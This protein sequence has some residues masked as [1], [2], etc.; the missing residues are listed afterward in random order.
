MIGPGFEQLEE[1][2]LLASH[3][4]LLLE[5]FPEDVSDHFAAD[6]VADPS[7]VM[8]LKSVAANGVESAVAIQSS[9]LVTRQHALRGD[10][11]IV[12]SAF[13]ADG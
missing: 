1:R 10:L 8:S 13:G 2:K 5:E 6:F 7:E 3:A 4:G 11:P 12:S 9:H